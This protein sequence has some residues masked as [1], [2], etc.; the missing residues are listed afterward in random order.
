MDTSKLPK[1]ITKYFWGDDL[2]QLDFSKNKKYILQVLL[3]RGDQKAIQ[4]LFS[5]LD[6]NFIKS[7][8]PKVKLS[9]KSAHFWRIYLA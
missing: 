8:L 3:E 2:S 5:V 4:W 7:T 9:E 6:R 1:F